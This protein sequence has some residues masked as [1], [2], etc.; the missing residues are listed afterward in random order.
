MGSFRRP[1][2][3]IRRRRPEYRGITEL[4]KWVALFGPD[5]EME[6]VAVG[7]D[8]SDAS[9]NAAKKGY[10]DTTLLKVLPADAAYVPFA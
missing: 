5:G 7:E 4:D 1:C 9:E 2:V 10:R 3:R 6:I 8:A